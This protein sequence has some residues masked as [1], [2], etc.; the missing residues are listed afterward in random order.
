MKETAMNRA[1]RLLQNYLVLALPPVLACIIWEATQPSIQFPQSAPLAERW[2]WEALAWNLMLWFSALPL[3]LILLMA[4]P[5][6]REK[7]LKRL[8]NLKDEDEREHHWSRGALCLYFLAKRPHILAL[9]LRPLSQRD[10][11]AR[12]RNR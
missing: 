7:T 9:R 2:L 12:G 1:I 8:A 6:A 3:F 11:I 5:S 10:A 4:A